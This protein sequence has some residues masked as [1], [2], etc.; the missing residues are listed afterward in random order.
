MLVVGG[1]TYQGKTDSAGMVSQAVGGNPT[2]GTLTLGMWS[3]DL[4]IQTLAAIDDEGGYAARLNNLGYYAD[5][6]A[7]ALMRFQSANDLEI[8]GE[9]DDNTKAKL[10]DIHGH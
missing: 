6:A 1:R 4:T 7:S 8:T 3:F 9:M 2:S 5:D 10:A